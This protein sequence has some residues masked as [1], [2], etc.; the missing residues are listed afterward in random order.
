M[1]ASGQRC[2][3][4]VAAETVG[5]KGVF[6]EGVSLCWIGAKGR[7]FLAE[8]S[9]GPTAKRPL[10]SASP[11]R[12]LLRIW[13]QYDHFPCQ[14][15]ITLLGEICATVLDQVY[16][17]ADKVAD[18]IVHLI[19]SHISKRFPRCSG[20]TYDSVKSMA[21]LIFICTPSLLQSQLQQ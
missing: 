18:L 8:G 7:G 4:E 10:R 3:L 9:E 5:G 2:L 15:M 11:A 12:S 17:A 20:L 19:L 1:N 21:S 6:G 13:Q 14:L 16:H